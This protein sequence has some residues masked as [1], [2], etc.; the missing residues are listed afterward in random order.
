MLTG[1]DAV[2]DLA[3]ISE[4]LKTR[5]ATLKDVVVVLGLLVKLVVTIRGNQVAIMKANKVPLREPRTDGTKDI[6][7][8]SKK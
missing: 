1:K 2:G 6:V 7:K 3:K 4:E 8:K 5:D